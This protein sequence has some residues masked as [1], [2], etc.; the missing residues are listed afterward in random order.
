MRRRA[1]PRR[2]GPAP[3]AVRPHRQPRTATARAPRRAPGRAPARGGRSPRRC[4]SARDRS[5]P[6]L[7]AGHPQ[8]ACHPRPRSASSVVVTMAWSKRA[9]ASS[10]RPRR[11]ASSSPVTSSSSSSG[12]S[13]RSAVSRS[14]SAR[15]SASSARRC[16]PC[17]PYRR[18]SRSDSSS[19]T[20]SRCGP[21]PVA[22]RSMSRRRRSRSTPASAPASAFDS[23]RSG[24]SPGTPPSCSS[25]AANAGASRAH[26]RSRA[27]ISSAPAFGHVVPAHERL[28]GAAPGAHPAQQVVALGERPRV[29][30]RDLGQRRPQPRQHAVEVR[31]PQ[32]RPGLHDPQPVGCEDQ[33]REPPQQP[34]HRPLGGAVDHHP[35]GLARP[36]ADLHDV[37][38]ARAEL[39]VDLDA[40]EVGAERDH[41]GLGGRARR[42][43]ERAEVDHLDQRRLAGAVGADDAHQAG[44]RA[45]PPGARSSG[46]RCHGRRPRARRR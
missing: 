12:C 42:V 9:T 7:P 45:R 10:S 6:H 40:G 15:I 19:S 8:E 20:S 24:S 28:L 33:H 18:R 44:R 14:A 41:L 4:G 17:D 11:S 37:A 39:G 21:A 34:L 2:S 46:S 35:L 1:P 22:A 25:R 23:R 5:C 36:V 16:S 3:R 13:P 31:A 29:V 38:A 43:A 27:A 26:R 30:G 32:R